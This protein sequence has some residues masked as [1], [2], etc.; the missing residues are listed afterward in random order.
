[1]NR[2][3]ESGNSISTHSTLFS[4]SLDCRL[5]ISGVAILDVINFDGGKHVPQH[6]QEDLLSLG[7]L[8]LCLACKVTIILCLCFAS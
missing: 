6:Q 8:L 7:K 4:S 1:M 5:R 3:S 2:F